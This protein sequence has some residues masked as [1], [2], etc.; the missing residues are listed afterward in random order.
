MNIFQLATDL[1]VLQHRDI[2]GQPSEPQHGSPCD[3]GSADAYYNRAPRPHYYKQ[4][5]GQRVRVTDLTP[6]ELSE[7]AY[8]YDNE[9]DRKDRADD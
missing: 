6:E 7:Y 5:D 9:H 8:G 3:R 4:I 1:A 2:M